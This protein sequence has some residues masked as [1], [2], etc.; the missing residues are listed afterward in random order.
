MGQRQVHHGLRVHQRRHGRGQ[1]HRRQPL[2]VRQQ[3][4]P[5]GVLRVVRHQVRDAGHAQRQQQ[6]H[7][8]LVGQAV[9]VVPST[10][11][12]GRSV[13]YLAPL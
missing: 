12:L 10:S 7:A 3:L 5:D 4:G 6:V 11:V 1:V 8:G 2:H 13:G 9:P